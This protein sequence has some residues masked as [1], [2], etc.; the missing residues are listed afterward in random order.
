MNSKDLV[1]HYLTDNEQG[2]KNLITWFLNEVMQKEATEQA[3]ADKYERTGSRKTYRNGTR[4]RSAPL[5]RSKDTTSAPLL[6]MW[7]E[8]IPFCSAKIKDPFSIKGHI[9]QIIVHIGL[10]VPT[11]L[12]HPDCWHVHRMIK[13]TVR[14]IGHN[15]WICIYSCHIKHNAL[16]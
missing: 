15:S 13:I 3:G 2:M 16:D 8:S 11:A 4:S 1:A 12:D 6:S 9:T 14:E 7:K 5:S 10:K